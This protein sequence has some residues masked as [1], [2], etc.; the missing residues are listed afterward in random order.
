MDSTA[1][2]SPKVRAHR[3]DAT[4]SGLGSSRARIP[5]ETLYPFASFT[6]TS[7]FLRPYPRQMGLEGQLRGDRHVEQRCPSPQTARSED[8]L[9]VFARSCFSALS[10]NSGRSNFIVFRPPRCS[11]I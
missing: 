2:A 4:Y 1:C 7:S 6:F 10:N 9:C 5:A 8:H 3:E 11:P